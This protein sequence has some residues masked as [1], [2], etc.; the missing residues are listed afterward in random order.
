ME[1]RRK[2]ERLKADAERKKEKEQQ[3][4]RYQRKKNQKLNP[5]S[6]Q[7]QAP[8]GQPAVDSI[9]VYI[10]MDEFNQI[11]GQDEKKQFLG[12]HLYQYVLRKIE[13]DE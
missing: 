5:E 7:N 8:V 11:A 10:P 2:D 1:Y 13:K 12:D 4:V 6:S 3:T 9:L